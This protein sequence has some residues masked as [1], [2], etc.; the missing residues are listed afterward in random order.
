MQEHSNIAVRRL[1]LATATLS[2]ARASWGRGRPANEEKMPLS[3][4]FP[5]ATPRQCR[6]LK[7]PAAIMEGSVSVLRNALRFTLDWRRFDMPAFP[8]ERVPTL[9]PGR[10]IRGTRE[11]RIVVPDARLQEVRAR[12][13]NSVSRLDRLHETDT[14][15]WIEAVSEQLPRVEPPVGCAYHT[16]RVSGRWA[17]IQVSATVVPKTRV[18]SWL[19]MTSAG[20]QVQPVE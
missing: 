6:L 12:V 19:R 18:V 9:R 16:P 3:P 2:A 17:A 15:Q 4:A 5:P 10:H 8:A 1:R 13:A 7:S 20:I 11:I 14:L